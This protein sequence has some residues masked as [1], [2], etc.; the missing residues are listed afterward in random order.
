GVAGAHGGNIYLGSGIGSEQ[1][2]VGAAQSGTTVIQTGLPNNTVNS[3][4]GSVSL[5]TSIG[6]LQV[7]GDIVT[8][9]TGTG[10][11]GSI[12]LLAPFVPTVEAPYQP[13]VN[14]NVTLSV[15]PKSLTVGGGN[16]FTATG[17]GTGVTV[18]AGAQSLSVNN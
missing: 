15:G 5:M 10:R 12:S 9:G 6:L 2:I 8:T 3:T 1:L 11:S 13:V 4:A 17:I 14:G 16:V 7:R 18:T